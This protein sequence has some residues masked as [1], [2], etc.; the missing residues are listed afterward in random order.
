MKFSGD[1]NL[2]V[3]VEEG[4]FEGFDPKMRAILAM[5][6]KLTLR[7]AAMDEADLAPLREAGM[8]D[9]DI[10]D[11]VMI[12]SYFNHMNRV[13]DALGVGLTPEQEEKQK[14][15]QQARGAARA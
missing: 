15:I 2:P 5:T 9:E 14:E 7:P 6:E 8:T 3:L 12:T 11:A 13:V 4:N 1:V 10:L